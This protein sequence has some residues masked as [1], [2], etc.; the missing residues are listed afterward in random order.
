MDTLA[1]DVGGT[2]IKASV[3]AADGE[4]EVS[5]VRVATTYPMPPPRLVATIRELVDSLPSYRRVSVGFPGVVRQGKVLSAPHFVTR[6]GPGSRVDPELVEA[7][8]G[9]DLAGAV[10]Q[11]LRRPTRVAND[12]DMQGA[13]VIAGEGLELVV[14]LGTGVGTGLFWQGRLAPHLELAH[15]PLHGDLT[16]N[17]WLGEAARKKAGTA[18]WRKRVVRTIS[19]L[20]TLLN[21]DHLFIGGGNSSRLTGHVPEGVTLVDNDAGI[22][23]GIRLWERKIL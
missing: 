14:T 12:A 1:V 20:H 9:F 18:K 5:R 10:R 19:V 23:G 6:R 3:L 4:M 17:E 8:A 13:A 16:Y 7:W 15:H 22:L 21:Y 11:A 2:G